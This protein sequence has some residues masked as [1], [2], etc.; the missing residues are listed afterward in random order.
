MFRLVNV[1]LQ[2]AA[3]PKATLVFLMVLCATSQA[4]AQPRQVNDTAV[5][6][7]RF[8]SHVSGDS[9]Y[10]KNLDWKGMARIVAL[11]RAEKLGASDV[12]WD[13]FTPVGAFNGTAEGRAYVCDQFKTKTAEQENGAGADESLV[14][15]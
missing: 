15:N 14:K 1:V 9:G 4:Q 6:S 7:C 11:R 8:V 5:R 3:T 10:G 2:P 13:R 12:V